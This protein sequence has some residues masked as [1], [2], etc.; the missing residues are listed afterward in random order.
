[1]RVVLEL[2]LAECGLAVELLQFF[3]VHPAVS[4]SDFLKQ[5]D[6]IIVAQIPVIAAKEAAPEVVDE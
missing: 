5:S 3:D 2:G 1:M 4:R 6:N